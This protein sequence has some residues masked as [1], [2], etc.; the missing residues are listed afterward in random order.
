MA[1]CIRINMESHT[2]SFHKDKNL[3]FI[4]ILGPVVKRMTLKMF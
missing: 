3:P 1:F 4:Q 2:F